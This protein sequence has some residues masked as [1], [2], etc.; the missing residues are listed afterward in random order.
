MWFFVIGNSFLIWSKTVLDDIFDDFDKM[1]DSILG[2]KDLLGKKSKS[3]G[4]KSKIDGLERDLNSIFENLEMELRPKSDIFSS[5]NPLDFFDGFKNKDTLL[6]NFI[7]YNERNQNQNYSDSLVLINDYYSYL[8]FN[9]PSAVVLDFV[10]SGQP[11]VYQFGIPILIINRIPWNIRSYSNR[12]PN[13]FWKPGIVCLD[14]SDITI[15]LK[16]EVMR[17]VVDWF[18]NGKVFNIPDIMSNLPPERSFIRTR[19]DI[20]VHARTEIIVNLIANPG[21]LTQKSDLELMVS[22]AGT[23]ESTIKS[24]PDRFYDQFKQIAIF[25]KIVD[26]GDFAKLSRTNLCQIMY[27]HTDCDSIIGAINNLISK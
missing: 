25:T 24:I 11:V 17:L 21:Q 15:N 7:A 14:G 27:K 5:I 12:M 16:I 6:T 8:K 10:P 22:L 19:R 18:K 20:L 4:T 23:D 26:G 3:P 2:P 1:I 13:K 9:Q